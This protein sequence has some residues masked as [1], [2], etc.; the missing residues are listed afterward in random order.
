MW[1]EQGKEWLGISISQRLGNLY[2][3]DEGAGAPQ[4]LR[5]W[6]SAGLGRVVELSCCCLFRDLDP[7]KGPKYINSLEKS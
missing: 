6:E 5:E 4:E 7:G 3:R 2:H 1:N